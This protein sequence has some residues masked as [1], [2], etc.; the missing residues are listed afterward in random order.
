MATSLRTA[1]TDARASAI[2]HASARP[3]T[4]GIWALGRIEARR[5][6]LHP[7]FLI[8][9][10]FGLLI[11]RGAIGSG[12]SPDMAENLTWLVGGTLIGML[13]GTILTANVAALRPHRDRM[14]ELF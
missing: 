10:A 11:L 1:L 9:T 7:S 3:S 6:L 14:Q 5:M 12:G 2:P 4:V 8:G 13:V